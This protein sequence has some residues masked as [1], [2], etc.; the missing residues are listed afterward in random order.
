MPNHIICKTALPFLTTAAAV[1]LGASIAQ[2]HTGRAQDPPD[3]VK[4]AEWT[5]NLHPSLGSN[6]ASVKIVFFVDY[7][8]PSCRLADPLIREAVSKRSDV[9]LIY[10]EFPLQMHPLA[11]PAAIVAENA[12]AHGTFDLAHRRLME[13]KTVTEDAIKEAARK[14]GVSMHETTQAADRIESDRSLERKANL[15][16]VPSFVVIENGK[17]TLM[18]KQQVLDFLKQPS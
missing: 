8:C 7:Q 6:S 2:A 3:S 9:A 5:S 11:N 17:S 10:R 18:N 1:V 16:H 12:R 13:G 15:S 14:A 4:P